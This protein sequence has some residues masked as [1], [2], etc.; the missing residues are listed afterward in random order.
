MMYDIERKEDE[1]GQQRGQSKLN[2]T[3]VETDSADVSARG[4]Q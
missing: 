3:A 1:K 2:A 4:M